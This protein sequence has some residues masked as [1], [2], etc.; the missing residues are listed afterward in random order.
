M[1][2]IISQIAI[3]I[4]GRLVL[5]GQSNCRPRISWM[6]SSKSMLYVVLDAQKVSFT[7]VP[8]T[9][10]GVRVTEHIFCAALLEHNSQWR[11]AM[12]EQSLSAQGFQ[13]LDFMC[14]KKLSHSIAEEWVICE[15]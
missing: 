3:Y 2:A 10:Q 12:V 5:L 15:Y 6:L 7:F 14:K 4:Q 9:H 11:S 8:P 1:A 13:Q